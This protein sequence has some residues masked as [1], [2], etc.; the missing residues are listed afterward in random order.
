MS[1]PDMR[2][3]NSITL[4]YDT[5]EDRLLVVINA[6]SADAGGYWLTRRL[7]L[8]FIEAANPF[9]DRMSPVVGKT[10]AELHDELATMEREVALAS[11]QGN[12]SRTPTAA[13]E[14]ASAAAELAVELTISRERQS[15]RLKLRGRKGGETALDYSRA[16][17]QRIVHEVEQ[18]AAKA[19]W[20]EGP[21]AA[22]P[23]TDAKEAKRR[24]H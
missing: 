24:A 6:G 14:S 8:R 16:L 21:P 2:P 19:G 10:P 12:M 9:L 4:H 11:T 18:E 22:P 23:P 20:R 1:E 3:P 15:F 13:L 5:D 7:A 17:L